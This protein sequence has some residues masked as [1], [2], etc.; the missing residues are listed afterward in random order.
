MKP[1]LF[2]L[3]SVFIFE[4][5][6]GQET[7]PQASPPSANDA[8]DRF[9]ELVKR[10]KALQERF[11]ALSSSGEDVDG[12]SRFLKHH[13]M[14]TMVDDFLKLEQESRGT[15]VGFSCLYHLVLAGASVGEPGYP[16]SKGKIAALE[17]L[18]RHYHDYSNIDTILNYLFSGA[19]IPEAEAFTRKLIDSTGLEYVRVNA[20][21]ELAKH[22]AL[23]A[24]LPAMCQS[25]LDVLDQTD[26]KN[27]ARVEHLKK[28][29]VE[30][31]SVDIAANRTEASSIIQQIRRDH[32]DELVPP[33]VGVRPPGIIEVERGE[34]DEVL[35]TTRSLVVD[36]LSA[37][38]FELNH[39]IGQLTPPIDGDDATGKPMSLDDFRGKVVVVMFSFKGCGPCEE[40]YPDNR[41]LIDEL[42]DEAFAFVG[43]QGDETIDTV[44]E[45]LQSGTITWRVWWEGKEKQISN[46]WNVLGWPSTYV[47]DQR[48]IVR[49]RNLRGQELATAVRSLLPQDQHS[50]L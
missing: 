41:R 5:C 20:L 23:E 21:F 33:R 15:K 43:V 47:L 35:K 24:N 3:L 16:V 7:R 42:S 28:L 39:S 17:I 2:V 50:N 4:P 8:S 45:S 44:H 26:P 46:R 38:Q 1:L 22:L 49:F 11:F 34:R 36:R 27:D 32:A 13:P 31:N 29:L 12:L 30:L 40:M 10:Y 18:G 9:E 48:G 19:R 14:N 37:V 6:L 25:Q